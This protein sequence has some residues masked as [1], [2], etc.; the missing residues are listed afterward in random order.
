MD[1]F[2]HLDRVRRDDLPE[3]PHAAAAALDEWTARQHGILSG[4]HAVG[5]FLDLLAEQGY[6]VATRQP[7]E[8]VEWTVWERR[9]GSGPFVHGQLGDDDRE[10]ETWAREHAARCRLDGG[11]AEVRRRLTTIHRGPW[12]VVESEPAP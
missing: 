3:M 4:S 10:P 12:E 7:E 11:R 5:L 2:E 6:T 9:A 1:D 8:I